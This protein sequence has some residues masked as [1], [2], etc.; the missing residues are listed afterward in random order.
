MFRRSIFDVIKVIRE[1]L[2]RMVRKRGDKKLIVDL[3]IK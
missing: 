1:D 2:F 3:S